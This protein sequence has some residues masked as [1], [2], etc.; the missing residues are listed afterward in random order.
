MSGG[1]LSENR[2]SIM[3]IWQNDRFAA[4][5]ESSKRFLIL[6]DDIK[7]KNGCDD[8]IKHYENMTSA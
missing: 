5:K 2:F 8:K 1:I 6:N 4:K 3:Q 7:T